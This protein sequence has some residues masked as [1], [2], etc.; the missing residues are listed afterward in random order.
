MTVSPR[1]GSPGTTV[2]VRADLR[3]CSRP[4][5]AHGFFQEVHEWGVDGLS[6]WLVLERVNGGRWYT[7]QYLVTKREPVGLGRF[8]VVCDN[9]IDGFATFLVQPS[10]PLVQVRVT[11]RAGGPGTTVGI[12]AE[13]GQCHQVY[14]YFYDSKSDGVTI[15]GGAKPIKPLRV[16]AAGRLTA[17][18]TVTRK[19]ATG[20][21]R[22]S[23]V[24][25]LEDG[26][27]RA[28]YASFQVRAPGHPGTGIPGHP[29]SGGSTVTATTRGS[30]SRPGSTPGSAAPPAA[31]TPSGCCC[32]PGC[33]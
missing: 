1:A 7:G 24:C 30:P 21:A 18:Y 28:G 31:S 2:K 9:A 13:V 6:S 17:S 33:C 23:A 20:P 26:T 19:D 10:N 29:S 15:A 27:A 11:A 25:G 32:Q 14:A 16:T 4:D 5:S 22:F 8:G 12:T 3:G